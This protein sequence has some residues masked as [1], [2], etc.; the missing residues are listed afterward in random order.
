MNLAYVDDLKKLF[1][2]LYHHQDLHASISMISHDINGFY[3]K[4]I[5][6]MILSL[7]FQI[8]VFLQIIMTL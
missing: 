4:N 5:S 1:L 7:Y 6:T 3:E 8:F 2:E